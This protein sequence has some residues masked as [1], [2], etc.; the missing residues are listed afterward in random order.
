[1][2]HDHAVHRPAA[3]RRAEVR[4]TEQSIRPRETRGGE[5]CQSVIGRGSVEEKKRDDDDGRRRGV[6]S[7]RGRIA[8]IDVVRVKETKGL[9]EEGALFLVLVS[10]RRRGGRSSGLS[11]SVC[12]FEMF[13]CSFVLVLT[14]VIRDVRYCFKGYY[15]QKRS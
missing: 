1:M 8:R 14:N 3:E 2:Q 6:Q 5:V 4:V 7:A 13:I 9:L 10:C 11:R 15:Y 12:A